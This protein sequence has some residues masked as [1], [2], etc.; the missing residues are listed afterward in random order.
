MLIYLVEGTPKAQLDA[1]Q[2]HGLGTRNVNIAKKKN[3]VF[4][5]YG[6]EDPRH[7]ENI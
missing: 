1:S 7:S 6:V 5:R 4:G 3:M 2:S